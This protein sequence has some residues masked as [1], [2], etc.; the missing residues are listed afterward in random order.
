[1][2]AV[3]LHAA[4]CDGQMDQIG[5]RVVHAFYIRFPI[6]SILDWQVLFSMNT[7][8]ILLCLSVL[9]SRQTKRFFT[10]ELL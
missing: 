6:R 3:L 10:S 9:E 5:Q 8:T 2:K 4:G 7:E 1:M